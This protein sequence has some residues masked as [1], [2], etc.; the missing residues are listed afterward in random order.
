MV[1]TSQAMINQL[2]AVQAAAIA[3][4]A[5]TESVHAE[6]G[7]IQERSRGVGHIRLDAAALVA[8]PLGATDAMAQRRVSL[9]VR[10]VRV[11]P[12]LHHAMA[13][14]LLDGW[15]AGLVGEELFD[16][17]D[18]VAGSVSASVVDQL[19]GRSGAEVRRRVRCAVAKVDEQWL[20]QRVDR[21]RRD[22]SVRRWAHE[23]GVDAWFGTFPAERSALAWAAV[24]DVAQRYRKDGSCETLDQARADAMLDLVL[25]RATARFT[26]QL[27]VPALI[28]DVA[29]PEAGS[30]G[31]RAGTAAGTGTGALAPNRPGPLTGT[32]AVAPSRT[33]PLTGTGAVAPNR[34]GPLTGTLSAEG[35]TD[36]SVIPAGIRTLAERAERVG[37]SAVHA[38]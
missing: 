14:G 33:G 10:E 25:G 9:A 35:D 17:P 4:I 22:R 30:V 32:G 21:A 27:T 19:P 8:G 6:D 18:H 29:A 38:S 20:R 5:A 31:L 16:A 2:G 11:M 28:G 13:A 26:V 15:R 1:A 24:D 34:P 37:T 36:G 3:E 23:P 7:T 12:S